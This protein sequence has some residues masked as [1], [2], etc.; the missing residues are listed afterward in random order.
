LNRDYKALFNLYRRVRSLPLV[1][2]ILFV[3]GL[4]Y[5][6]AILLPEYVKALV[7][8]HFGSYL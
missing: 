4:S 2:K 7:T 6:F 3:S 8:H 5:D 1:K